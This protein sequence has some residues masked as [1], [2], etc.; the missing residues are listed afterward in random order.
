MNLDYDNKLENT[1]YRIDELEENLKSFISIYHVKSPFQVHIDYGK[2][3]I[4]ILEFCDGIKT[5]TLLAAVHSHT[6]IGRLLMGSNS[7]YM[8]HLDHCS[9]YIH[10]N[11]SLNQGKN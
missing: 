4:K 2:P 1:S 10:K 5:W 3:Y 9:M 8:L 11:Y 7:D 6:G